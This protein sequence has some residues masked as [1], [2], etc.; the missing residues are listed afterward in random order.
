[1]RFDVL[2]RDGNVDNIVE[3]IYLV[4]GLENICFLKVYGDGNCFYRV[5]FKVIFGYE[6]RYIEF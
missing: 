1:M 5:F 4:D 3:V 2:F 6:G